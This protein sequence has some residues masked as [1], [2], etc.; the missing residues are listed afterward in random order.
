MGLRANSFRQNAEQC[1]RL[2]HDS[3]DP[4]QRETW[5]KLAEE[6]TKMAD[7]ADVVTGER[8]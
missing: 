2:A 3:R 4:V 5:L 7:E 1:R 8:P 6:W